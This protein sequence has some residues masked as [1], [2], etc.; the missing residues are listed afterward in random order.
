M[1]IFWMKQVAPCG[2]RIAEVI[3]CLGMGWPI[4]FECPVSADAKGGNDAD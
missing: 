4:C 2:E 1:K 3:G